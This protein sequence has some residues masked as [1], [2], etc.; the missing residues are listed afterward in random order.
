MNRQDDSF[1]RSREGEE[2]KGCGAGRGRSRTER[3]AGGGGRLQRSRGG[4]VR[5]IRHRVSGV[6]SRAIGPRDDELCDRDRRST[7]RRVEKQNARQSLR[8]QS[9]VDNS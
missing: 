9:R 5:G 6:L 3:S 8:G 7:L 4:C 2:R 1:D